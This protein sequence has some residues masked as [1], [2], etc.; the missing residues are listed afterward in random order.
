MLI[1]LCLSISR[2]LFE[3]ADNSTYIYSRSYTIADHTNTCTH[4]IQGGGDGRGDG[5]GG[6]GG[7]DGGGGDCDYGGVG[8]VWRPFNQINIFSSASAAVS[9]D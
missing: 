8:D 9:P 4:S 2:S 6:E 7:G 3:D 5:G 1:F